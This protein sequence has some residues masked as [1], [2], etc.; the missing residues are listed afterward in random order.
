MQTK[1]AKYTARKTIFSFSR[2]PEKMVFLKKS[3]WNMIFLVLS[4]KMIFL[5][6]ENMISQADG[7][8]T[9]TFSKKKKKKKYTEI[10]FL[11]MSWKVGLFKKDR[12][13]IWFFLYFRERWYFSPEKMVFFPGR[14]TRERGRRPSSRNTRKHVFSIWYAPRPP[15]KKDQRWSYPAKI[16]LK[17]IDT[18]DRHPRK[19][20]RN[21]LYFHVDLYT[22]VF[23]YYPPEKLNI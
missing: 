23:I 17:V 14:R 18:H 21:S 5:F 20:P 12:T 8:W 7:K 13:G 6:P 16:H 11:Q 10:Y 1:Y 2:P 4:G 3:H 19:S 15:A 9:M 22:D